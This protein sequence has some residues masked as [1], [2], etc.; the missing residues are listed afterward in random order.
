MLSPEHVRARRV[1]G[2]LVVQALKGKQRE[3]ALEL[4]RSLLSTARELEGERR[5]TLEE[6]LRAAV[7]KPSERKLVEGLAKL[8][9]DASELGEPTSVDVPGL[10]RA[11]FE[12][13]ALA[14]RA[15]SFDRDAIVAEV[16]RE[17]GVDAQV[18][19]GALYSD[20]RSE[21]RLSKAAALTADQL[22]ERYDRGVRQAVLLRA[23]QVTARV[24][25][26]TPHAYRALFNKLKFRR[27]LHRIEPC[28]G[29][30]RIEID[31]PYS[32]FESVTKYGLALALVLP[33]LEDCDE[34]AL[35]AELS[36]GPR[37]ERVTYRHTRSGQPGEVA[38]PPLTDDVLALLRSFG[39]L[40]SA[41]RAEP[42][43]AL[44][45]LPGVGVCAPDLEFR[46][47]T[48]GMRIY[49]EVLGFWSREAV[50]RRVE[51]FERGLAVPVLFA[52]SSRL[53]VSEELLAEQ[54]FG[55]LYVYKGVMSPRAV[56]RHLDALAA[57]LS[58]R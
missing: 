55:A 5:A 29:G 8:L 38:E 7:E 48:D 50:F 44:V 53:R 13:A 54:S 20:L 28:E 37:R 49:L 26:R 12:R 6:A 56:E 10:R 31:G 24:K 30:Y 51:L 35:E 4:A 39:E 15:G 3:R 52:A 16:A 36:W 21:E 1:G 11:L 25:C 27:L 18:V 22:L 19:E 47:T 23:I 2:E 9:L 58:R 33:A 43:S 14:R 41:W 34:L 46:R 45:E 40:Q 17:L 42:S 32:L 57:G